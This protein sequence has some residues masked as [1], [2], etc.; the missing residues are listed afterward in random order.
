MTCRELHRL[1]LPRKK[2]KKA[3]LLAGQEAESLTNGSIKP[4]SHQKATVGIVT[5]WVIRHLWHLGRRHHLPD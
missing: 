2:K 3:S 4:N 5:L 1:E